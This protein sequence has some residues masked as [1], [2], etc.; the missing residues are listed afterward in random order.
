ML[1]EKDLDFYRTEGYV[2]VR[3]VLTPVE[4]ERLRSGLAAFLAGAAKVD[5][6]D[7]VFDLEDTHTRANPRVRRIK[8]PH[9]LDPAFYDLIRSPKLLGL[10]RPLLG[11][12]VRLQNSKLNL[13]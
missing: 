2:V 1:T 13:K 8:A 3:D 12:A 11:P 9:K 7:D 6:N 5:R 10:M 4:L